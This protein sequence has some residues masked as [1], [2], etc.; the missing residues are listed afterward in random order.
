LETAH[1]FTRAGAVAT[2]LHVNRL[3]EN[4]RL[5]DDFALLS[6]PGGFS[7]GDDIAAGR[8]LSDQLNRSLGDA[9]RRFVDRGRPVIGICNGFQVLIQTDLL[10]GRLEKDA[11][12]P[13]ALTENHGG[14]YVCRWVTLKKA[15]KQCVWTGDWGDDELV[16]LPMAHAEGRLVFRDEESLRQVREAGRIALRYA[17]PARTLP[18]DL[19]VNPNGSADDI[20]G[21]CDESGLVLGLMPHPERYVDPMQHPAWTRMRLDGCLPDVTPG[22]R[23]FK[24]AVEHV[25]RS[26]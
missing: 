26:R 14:Q 7:Y 20:A 3:V 25:V 24:N 17:G 19:P 23:L 10:P 13:C 15:A 4:P 5:L 1:A 12:K 22:L 18:G 21:L 8:I 6:V 9:L 11:Q 2:T 16:E